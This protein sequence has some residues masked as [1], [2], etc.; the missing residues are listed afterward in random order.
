[1]KLYLRMNGAGM[2]GVKLL[3]NGKD[4]QMHCRKRPGYSEKEYTDRL[5][6]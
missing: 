2:S 4:I 5:E 6:V 3:E 1:M